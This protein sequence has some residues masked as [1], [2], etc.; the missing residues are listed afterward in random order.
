L[1][2]VFLALCRFYPYPQKE[3]KVRTQRKR[4][5]PTFERLVSSHPRRSY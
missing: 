4:F 1:L 3:Y 5:F 2:I